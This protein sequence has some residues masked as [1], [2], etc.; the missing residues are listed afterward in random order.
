MKSRRHHFPLKSYFYF[1]FP[2]P[3]SW[4]TFEFPMSSYV[5]QCRQR[6]IPVRRCRKCGG[7]RWNHVEICFRSKVISTSGFVAAI[8]SF[9]CRYLRRPCSMSGLPKTMMSRHSQTLIHDVPV[10]NSAASIPSN[11][12][13]FSR[14]SMPVSIQFPV[15]WHEI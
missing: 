8:L 5:G 9:G 6:H 2:L 12:D 7:S 11:W 15:T 14:Y 4:P 1:R 3:V 13:H 10:K